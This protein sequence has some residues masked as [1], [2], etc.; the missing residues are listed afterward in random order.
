MIGFPLPI[1]EAAAFRR[2]IDPLVQ[3]CDFLQID[4][5]NR[6]CVVTDKSGAEIYIGFSVKPE[7]AMS[8]S[9][10]NPAFAGEG[11]T[12]VEIDTT[13]PNKD[14][15]FRPFEI[16]VS[17][18]FAGEST[19]LVFDLAD[20]RQ[21][22]VFSHGAKISVDISAFSYKPEIYD[23]QAAFDRAQS[24]ANVQVRFASNFFI[25]AG[26]FLDSV[27]GAANADGPTSYADL[28]GTVIKAQLRANAA[29]RGKFW[30]ALV[31][32]YGGSTMDVVLDPSTVRRKLR[33]GSILTG[34]F[35][36]SARLTQK[37]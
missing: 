16:Q 32:T 36:L 11:R 33:A 7:A 29:G 37:H 27:G 6:L 8:V 14:E 25:P 18:R 30:W 1:A 19:P 35:W 28:A 12:S 3:Q 24:K 23:N 5:R 10:V 13:L 22:G 9:T 4:E 15:T 20:P 2:S 17:A 26:M 31:R 21:R 34:R